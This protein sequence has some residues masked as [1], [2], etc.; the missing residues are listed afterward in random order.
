MTSTRRILAGL[1][2]GL[3]VVAAGCGERE[4]STTATA[5]TAHAAQGPSAELPH[6]RI[7]FRRFLGE[8][9][10]RGAIFVMRTDGSGERQLTD[11]EGW[12]D[13]YPDWSPDGRLIAFQS[14]GPERPCSV[15]TVDANGGQ[16]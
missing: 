5:A 3:V 7:A 9:R 6:G 8:D 16:P 12:N 4:R 15:W 1:G 11:P 10:T 14:C 13:D 2:V